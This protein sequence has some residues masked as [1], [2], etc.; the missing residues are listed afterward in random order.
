MENNGNLLTMRKKNFYYQV[1]CEGGEF[2]NLPPKFNCEWSTNCRRFR[3]YNTA[4]DFCRKLK[5]QNLEPYIEKWMVISKRSPKYSESGTHR[6][7]TFY[8]NYD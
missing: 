6:V 2:F 4:Y 8:P 7:V 3:R 5:S 1:R